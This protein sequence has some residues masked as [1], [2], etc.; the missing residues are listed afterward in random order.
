MGEAEKFVGVFFFEQRTATG[1]RVRLR[2]SQAPTSGGHWRGMFYYST[3]KPRRAE[4]S[5]L[6][7]TTTLGILQMHTVANILRATH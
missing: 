4:A 7:S 2:I 6:N 5:V 3:F 1:I